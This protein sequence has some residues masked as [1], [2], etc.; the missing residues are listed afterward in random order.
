M[1]PVQ[2]SVLSLMKLS[3]CSNFNKT[4]SGKKYFNQ[5]PLFLEWHFIVIT[6]IPHCI[7]LKTCPFSTLGSLPPRYLYSLSSLPSLL[8]IL[9]HH[10]HFI[11]SKDFF[12]SFQIL[13]YPH[14]ILS[15]CIQFIKALCNV[16]S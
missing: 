1:V 15:K 8:F 14:S 7:A 6:S 13:F 4:V 11:G 12:F 5:T 16:F 9:L 2:D 3:L 10:N